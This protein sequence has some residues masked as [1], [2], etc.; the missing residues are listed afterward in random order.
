MP[1]RTETQPKTP[2]EAAQEIK[3]EALP[4]WQN[5]LKGRHICPP[6]GVA[7]ATREYGYDKDQSSEDAAP[8]IAPGG[9]IPRDSAKAKE[10]IINTIHKIAKGYS[11][12]ME[13]WQVGD[14]VDRTVRKLSRDVALGENSLIF[15]GD[16]DLEIYGLTDVPAVSESGSDWTDRSDTGGTPYTDLIDL[17]QSMDDQSGGRFGMT[18]DMTLV[19]H[20]NTAKYLKLWYQNEVEKGGPTAMELISGEFDNI[21]TTREIE[22]T[23]A[24]VM[25]TGPEIA[26]LIVADD[27]TVED[28]QYKNENQRYETNMYQ[29]V[30]PVFYQYG[31]TSAQTEA[32]AE[33]TDLH[34]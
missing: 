33:L 13:D 11:I 14:V 26:E 8:I 7:S 29:R 20:S 34:S 21:L 31:D 28:P 9:D 10:R 4:V 25:H 16:G 12:T 2:R 23:S 19:L 32:V 27:F 18:E 3:D 17:A 24:Y 6:R 22:K 15:S 30:L 1:R 5:E